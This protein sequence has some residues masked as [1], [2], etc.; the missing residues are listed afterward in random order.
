MMLLSIVTL[1][2]VG[3]LLTPLVP[4]RSTAILPALIAGTIGITVVSMLLSQAMDVLGGSILIEHYPWLPGI[5]LSPAFRLDALG[6]FFALIIAGMGLLITLYAH[7]YL[8]L[9]HISEPTRRVVSRMPS[10]A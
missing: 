6:L 7:F 2:L 4:R 8:S 5:G 3:A 10:S 1:P 9:I